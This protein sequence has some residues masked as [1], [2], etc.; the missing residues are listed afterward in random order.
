MR[1]AALRDESAMAVTATTLARQALVDAAGA[2][3]TAELHL[4]IVQRMA[5]AEEKMM[6]KDA[7][8]ARPR[9][10]TQPPF[11]RRPAS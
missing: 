6:E 7:V 3:E 8:S 1:E 5:K 11:S 10:L 2:A 4:K 9:C